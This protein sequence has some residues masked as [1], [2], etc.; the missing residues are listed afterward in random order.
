M[1]FDAS[2]LSLP[3]T[4]EADLCVIGSGAGGSA[5]A[6]IAAEAGMRVVMLESG[7]YL[8]PRDMTQREEQM[9]TRL[10]WESGA[11]ATVDGSV[12]II[13]GKGVG[14]STLHNLNLCKRI[15]APILRHWEET[16]GL[17]NLPLSKWK[18]LY[19][20]VE[21]LLEVGF[22]PDEMINRHNRL[23]QR[24]C[25]A[26]GWQGGFMRHNRTGCVGS[27]FCEVG[28][29][30]DAK[31]NACK[32]LVPR[33]ISAGGEIITRCHA[34]RLVHEN[35]KVKAVEAFSVNPFNGKPDGKITIHAKQVCVSASA[36]GTAALLLRSE[37]PHPEGSIGKSLHIHPAVV[38][39][40]EFDE[41]IE[42][43]KGI[44][45]AYE[46]TQFLD[47]EAAHTNSDA[48]EFSR[49]WIINAFAHPMGAS[50]MMPGI[51]RQ[52]FEMMQRYPNMAVLTA[53]LH[54]STNGKVIPHGKAGLKIDYRLNEEDR[55]ELHFGLKACAQLLLAAGAKRV[56]VPSDPL[57]EIARPEQINLIDAITISSGNIDVTAVHPMSSVPMGDDKNAA[58]VD[59][60]GKFHSLDGLWIADGSLFPTSIG[61]PPQLS[62]Y[63]L[64][65][66]VGREIV[67][68]Q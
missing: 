26:L 40:G 10:F 19:D 18:S 24:G 27:G 67:K 68:H 33:I 30:F 32:V 34:S 53:M 7:D 57:I 9:F 36:T 11:R 16:R 23:L 44:P 4:L 35:G 47:F 13:Q 21:M 49:L 63:S 5:A 2:T 3:L 62:I 38:A 20:E 50:T 60:T 6:M 22:I 45:Q 58:A 29:A 65:L 61:V 28:C 37:V 55:A 43:W 66:H 12:K 42:A 52:H 25:E 48:S 31:N 1:I 46:C 51:G 41:R 17:K 39:V 56:I 14:G 15:P 8:T 64:G 54:D 59:S